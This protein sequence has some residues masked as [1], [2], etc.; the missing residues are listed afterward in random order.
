MN[1]VYA[2]L[3]NKKVSLKENTLWYTMGTMCSSA[4]SF[5]LMIYVTRILGVDEAGVF[6]ISYSVGQLML[7]IGW[8]GTRQFQVSDIN[9]EFKFSDYLSL[10]LFMTIIMMVGCLIY[11]VFLHFNTY[12]MLVTFLYCLFLICDVF[13]DLFSARFQQVDKLFLSGMSYII[14]ILGY[15]LVI[16]FSLLC[17]KNLIVAIVLAMIYSA[18]ELTFFDL[19]LIKRISQIKIEFHMDKIIQLIKNCFPLFI[20]SFLTTF[21][22]NVPK[23]AIELNFDS[24]VQTYYN[25]IFMPSYIINLFCMFIFVPLYTSIAN[26][27][28]NS[29]KDKFINTVVKLMI[30]DVLLSLV[31]FAGCYFLGIPLL[32]LVYGVD[33]HSVK[34]SFLVLIVAGCFTSMNSILSYIFTVIRRQKFMIY[35]YVVAMVLA[36]VMVKTLTLNYGIFGASLDYLIGIASITVMFMLGLVLVLRKD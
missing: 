25:I 1:N 9:E 29:T 16:L 30:F 2:Y 28:L 23:N 19:Q 18:L 24:S 32:E 10:K 5:L 11:S 26:T 12:K 15:N 34:S 36:Q 14:R 20:S 7:S 22:V 21:I 27:W 8:F 13:A 33:L 31:V 4:T 35:I 6:S 3:L 17:F